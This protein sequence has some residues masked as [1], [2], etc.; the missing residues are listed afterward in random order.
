MLTNAYGHCCC[1]CQ[2]ALLCILLPVVSL[3]LTSDRSE[4]HI[5]RLV[6]R[7]G[8]HKAPKY[9]PYIY[10][11]HIVYIKKMSQ[12][13]QQQQQQQQEDID[14]LSKQRE[15]LAELL[16]DLNTLQSLLLAQQAQLLPL[17][18]LQLQSP[19]TSTPTPPKKKWIYRHYALGMYLHTYVCIYMYVN[20]CICFVCI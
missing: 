1:C 15:L 12:E 18:Q 19:S 9:A 20:T 11:I 6:A 3:H 16:N 2:F 13:K 14:Y 17:P 7:Q 4:Q 5:C 10:H 8:G